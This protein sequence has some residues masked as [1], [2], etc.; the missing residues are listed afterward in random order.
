MMKEIHRPDPDELLVQVLSEEQR[1]MRGETQNISRLCGW[2][3]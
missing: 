3:G 1:R 2:C